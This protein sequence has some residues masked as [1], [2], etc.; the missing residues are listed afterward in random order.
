MAMHNMATHRLR[1]A[2]S[3]RLLDFFRTLFFHGFVLAGRGFLS[4]CCFGAEAPATLP[5]APPAT[6]VALYAQL[7]SV[8]L[9]PARVYRIRDGEIIRPNLTLDFEDGTLA[10]T[11]DVCGRVTGAFFEGD[12]EILLRPPDSVERNSLALFTGGAILE[13]HFV[14]SYLRFDDDTLSQLQP[15][16]SPLPQNAD[17]FVNQW[18]PSARSLASLDALRLVLNFSRYLPC[19]T[20]PRPAVET[21]S[22]NDG[23]LHA[24]IQGRKLGSFEV[25]FDS[26]AVEQLSAGKADTKDGA[27]FFDVWTSFSSGSKTYSRREDLT[28]TNYKIRARVRPPSE[29]TADARVQ[30]HVNRGGHKAFL[31]ELSRALKI[32]SLQA[33]GHALEFIQNP[34]LEG[35]QLNRRGNDLVAV[36]FP[37]PLQAG[38]TVE[39]RFKYSGDVLSD[40]GSGLFYVGARGTWYPNRGFSLASF[41]LEFHYPPAWTLLATGTQT[42]VSTAPETATDLAAPGDS[43]SHWVSDRPIPVAGFNL[44]KYVRADAL[45]GTVQVRSYATRGVERSFPASSSATA[46]ELPKPTGPEGGRR[47]ESVSVPTAPPSPAQHGQRVAD[48]A[49]RA[50]GVF[51]QWFG[52]YPY[53]SLSLT[54]MPGELSQGWPSLVFLSSYGFLDSRE[55]TDARLS[56]VDSILSAQVLAHETAHQWWGDLVTWDSYHDQWLVEALANYSSLLLLEKRDPQAFRAVLEKYREDLLGKNKE[57]EEVMTAGPVTLGQRLSSSHF[58]SGYDAITYGRGTW[59]LHM[60]RC[61]LRDTQ[62]TRGKLRSPGDADA[63]V[64]LSVLRKLRDDF[65]GKII[66][67]PDVVHAFQD[68]LPRSLW[69]ENRKSLDWFSESWVRGTAIPHYKLQGVRILPKDSTLTA[70]GTILQEEAPKDMVTLIPVYGV[71][72]A[73]NLVLLGQVF[74]DGPETTFRFSAP[75]G[76]QKIVLDPNQTILSRLK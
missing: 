68:A 54:Q 72:T 53:R 10:F 19:S 56:S 51:S 58:P 40:A 26:N 37:S 39:L 45:A 47:S 52:S 21:Q 30:L 4:L 5:P 3:S 50:V 48:D 18:D 57:N 7:E 6:A 66:T 46:I 76:V 12:G 64:F 59:L 24:R 62:A 71:T 9:D 63:E 23:F 16:L 61:M 14:T 49:A 38:Q 41:D 75:A 33:D 27:V 2:V 67:T 32:H 8:G 43:V 60:L 1:R 36:V 22:E 20:G 42:P 15:A 70:T 74:A 65:E 55:R 25:Y 31:F 73:K 35:T 28:I 17:L 44:G 34:S 69:Y 13:E 29:L 11:H